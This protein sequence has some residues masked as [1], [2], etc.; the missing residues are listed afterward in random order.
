MNSLFSTDTIC[1]VSTPEG[2]GALAVIRLSGAKAMLICERIFIPAG[3]NKLLS[4]RTYPCVVF[5]H[6]MDGDRL[7]D[8]AVITLFKAPASF[9]G[10][11]TA[12]LS[13]HGSPFIRKRVMELLIENGARPA[14]EGEFT[15]RAFMNGKMDLS[16]AEAV[17]DLIHSE[18][19]AEHRVAM[20]QMRGGFSEELRELREKLVNFASLIEL[21]L[22]FGEEDVE[23]ADRSLL[24]SHVETVLEKMDSL[25]ASFKLGNVIK[26]G[27]PVAILGE[28]NAGK[29]TLLNALLNEE[30]AIV[31]EIAGTTRDT[32]EDE[33][34][35]NGLLFRFIDT[36]GIRE[37]KDTIENI[38]IE[39]ALEKAKIA[40]TVL[41]LADASA[42]NV[43]ELKNLAQKTGERP[44]ILVVNKTDLVND[45]QR[46]I[47]ETDILAHFAS[48]SYVFISAA[49]K[50]EIETLKNL[51]YNSLDTSALQ[52]NRT[53]VTNLRHYEALKRS[54]EF[55]RKVLSDLDTH[56]SADFLAMDIRQAL[57][58]LGEITGE[59]STDDLLATIFSKF[60]IGK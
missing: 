6:V 7:L 23:F 8:E 37:T 58:H 21:E 36:A 51:L 43:T 29:S 55:L 48:M 44:K 32:V 25:L 34:A 18:S 53:V 49:K 45:T 4:N 47:I 56:I 31:S 10:E 2:Y 16:R 52:S 15:K 27:V 41:L 46:Q 20:H 22:D 40:E 1:A 13:L 30:R 35:I 3:K 24:K 26:K 33:L 9:T 14:T 17:A 12:E 19:E 28:P 60:C 50:Q 38:G 42:W 11:D 39:R 54:T 57:F 59:I 5:G